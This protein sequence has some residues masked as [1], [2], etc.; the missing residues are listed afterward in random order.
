VSPHLPKIRNYL[1]VLCLTCLPLP[2]QAASPLQ[3]VFDQLPRSA[4]QC[5]AERAERLHGLIREVEL[6]IANRV[7]VRE[8][9]D[10][11]AILSRVKLMSP[12]VPETEARLQK[13]LTL[14]TQFVSEDMKPAARSYL[15][16]TTD[17]IDLLGRLRV[18]LAEV[19]EEA[20]YRLELDSAAFGKLV[21]TVEAQPTAIAALTLS[22]A[23][24]NPDAET[25]IAPFSQEIKQR[26]LGL[27]DK[28]LPGESVI[29][30]VE[31]LRQK[32]SAA[33]KVA[34]A[35]T[36]LKIGLPQDWRPG[37]G[38]HLPK[39]EITAKELHGILQKTTV[40]PGRDTLKQRKEKLLSQLAARQS[41]GVTQDTFRVNGF[42]LREGDWFLM[43][44]P[45]P[46]NRFTDLS[47]G[48]FTH[49]GVVAT[50]VGRDGVRR[51]VIVDLP[52]RGSRIP[53][54][55]VDT[56]LRQTL[57]YVFLRHEDAETQRLMGRAAADMIG[58]GTQFDL[59]FKTD[60]V[61]D[62]EGTNLKG[63]RVHTYC[64]GFL[65][66]CALQT[67]RPESEFFP[68]KEAPAG[69]HTLANLQRMGLSI[70]KDFV[71]PTGALFSKQMSIVGQ[72]KPLY[73]P[74]REIKEAV[75]DHF[76]ECMRE[77]TY[78]ASLDTKQ[79]LVQSLA[80]LSKQNALLARVLAR[81]NNV[82]E[83]MDLVS[84]ARAAAAVEALDQVANAHARAF[85]VA[86]DAIM[87][88]PGERASER[89]V[90]LYRESQRRHATLLSRWQQQKISYRELRSS[91]V[92][93]YR[94]EGRRE[95][96]AKFFSKPAK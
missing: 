71:S 88:G 81:A 16:M 48:L 32:E 45:S 11:A 54:T 75:Y 46:Y 24:L 66:L 90:E 14:R 68:I 30:L 28:T 1:I 18:L 67:K 89:R 9:D 86:L 6:Q 37:Q 4:Q 40:A 55:N 52:E 85:H 61:R 59:T 80:K 95:L 83:H 36:L 82:S 65:L 43:R 22:Y 26:V 33:L 63:Q 92:E 62:L 12:A 58:N 78:E 51:F 38:S 2:L 74:G 39:P 56:Y 79:K 17:V 20:T 15:R 25:G 7:T 5:D 70:G 47:P 49:V 27:L 42:D 57:H 87:Y 69:G 3:Q 31:M 84:A 60:R 72:C 76:A 44:N 94:D 77:K 50:E 34:A 53:A 13:L 73:E 29:T 41:R 96:E 35:E 91:L 21:T 64:A 93:Y 10:V 19:V 8:T 23:L